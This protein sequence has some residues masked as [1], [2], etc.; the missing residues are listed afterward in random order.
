MDEEGI[1][2]EGQTLVLSTV[3]GGKDEIFS[4]VILVSREVLLGAIVFLLELMAKIA[5]I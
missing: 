4:R 3:D 2:S 5:K 1:E